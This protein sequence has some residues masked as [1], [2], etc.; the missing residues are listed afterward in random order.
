MA[1]T[2][3]RTSRTKAAPRP[4]GITTRWAAVLLAL[5]TIA[6]FHQVALEGQT[7]VAPDATAPVGFVRMGEQSLY[8]D[9]EYPLWNPYVFL[10]MPSFASGAYNPLIY[11]PDWPLALIA[12]VV[13]LPDQTWLLLYY[14]LG[15]FFFFL[16]ARE[17]GARSEGALLG[18]VAWMFAPN[19]VAVGSH[20]HG[21][22]LVNSAYI[23]LLLWLTTRWL[24]R[25]G[26]Q[27]LGGLALAG[28]FQM[29]RGHAQ[30]A[31]YT[32]LA[33]GLYTSIDLVA[34]LRPRPEGTPAAPPL[35][36]KLARAAGVV[37]AMGLAFAIAGF[38]NLPL[39]DYAQY[40]IRGGGPGGGVGIDY[41]TAWSLSG[42]EL[43]TIVVPGAVGFG[44]STYWGTMPFTDYPNAYVGMITA[45]LALLGLLA[46][47]RAR[48]FAVA[49]ALV[50]LMISF[51]RHFPLYGFLYQHLPLFNKF[52]VP[53]MI[54]VLFQLGVALGAAWGWSAVIEPSPRS[55]RVRRTLL[56]IG[57]ALALLL[58]LGAVGQGAWRDGYLA[59]VHA[60]R[61]DLPPDAAELA[62]RGFISDLLR[63]SLLG[64]AALAI[65]LLAFRR[66]LSPV[67]ASALA[68]ILLL[69]EIWP[70]SAR[71]V[72]PVVGPRVPHVLDQGRDDVVEFLEKQGPPGSFRIWPIAEIQ[73]N[74]F[75]G[76]GVASIGGY[77]AAKPRLFQDLVD[78]M[79]VPSPQAPVA[80][81]LPWMRLLAIRYL[82]SQES[83]EVPW[84]RS[85]YQGSAIVFE[86]AM[87][88]PRATLVGYYRV[89]PSA[90]AALDSVGRAGY[91]PVHMT[92]L[93]SDPH[94]ALGGA[95]VEGARATITESRLNRVAVDVDAPAPALLR[96]ADLWYPDWVATVDGRR[97]PILRVDY[98]LRAV[99]VAAGRHHVEFRFESKAARDGLLLSCAGLAAAL[100]LLAFGWWRTRRSPRPAE[101]T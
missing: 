85:V 15:A 69:L 80:F 81:P 63:V 43:P 6:L 50:A 18:A 58:V 26:L 98:A 72:G 16:M 60:A 38:Y 10:G 95:V 45:A 70:V 73:S 35:P 4:I 23:P 1:K 36:T 49:I 94:L 46:W 87:A 66:S 90:A 53:V 31:F 19:L 92:W 47:S 44:G 83:I 55:E 25:G 100:L 28:G 22:Q 7:F 9:H 39:R 5:L 82:V 67:V 68:S 8:H 76:F 51:G 3:S 2:S 21:S 32:W 78:S 29:L 75:A 14:F 57:A 56:A 34:D 93:T 27:N 71:V 88:L 33:V 96:L 101:A 37:A 20:G 24:S 48:A 97:A 86:N 65:A 13:P 61:P 17:W 30:I 77:H 74:R 79:V 62:F 59:A 52:R 89:A 12:K 42:R 41:A 64:L 11:P 84:L 91:D 54:L 40:S 99:P